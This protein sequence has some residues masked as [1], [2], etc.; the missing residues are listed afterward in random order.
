MIFGIGDFISLAP[1]ILPLAP[2][3]EKAAATAQRYMAD[4]AAKAMI[5]TGQKI[6]ADPD[7]KDA[8]EVFKEVAQILESVSQ[9]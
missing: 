9:G 7:V 4:P 5:A 3:L 1:K 2:R 8:I 6:L